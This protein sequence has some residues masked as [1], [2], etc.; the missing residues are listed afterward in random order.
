VSATASVDLLFASLLGRG[1]ATVEASTSARVA[2][3]SAVSGLRPIALCSANPDLVA[4]IDGGMVSDSVV[5]IVFDASNAGCGG[6]VPGN[7]AVL[8]FD[9]G[10]NSMADAQSWIDGGFPGTVSVGAAVAGDPGIPSPAL[11]VDAIVGREVLMP[12]FANPRN[13]GDGALYDVVG[14]VSVTVESASLNGPASS[15]HLAVRFRRAVVRGVPGG[16]TSPGFGTVS[17]AVCSFDGQGDCS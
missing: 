14:F 16:V 8:D 5:E 6:D 9:G 10:A 17:V 2:P 15:R 3:S 11:Q 4:W 13:G 1:S 7:W 12:V